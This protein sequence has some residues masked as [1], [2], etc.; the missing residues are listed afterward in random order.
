MKRYTKEQDS[1][2]LDV[3]I[4][5]R[6][7]LTPRKLELATQNATRRALADTLHVSGELIYRLGQRWG[8]ERKGY[9]AR[10]IHEEA[11]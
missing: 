3:L 5:I 9:K 1:T 10:D 6:N 7:G 4:A 2:E 11:N 8:I